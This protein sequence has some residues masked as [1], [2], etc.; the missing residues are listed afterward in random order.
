MDLMTQIINN[1]QNLDKSLD[2]LLREK[3]TLQNDIQS[4][5]TENA[6][7]K[8]RMQIIHSEMEVYIKELKEIRAYYVSSNDN[9]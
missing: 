5:K 3:N 9:A 2:E 8:K 4:L 1:L 6:D 7:L